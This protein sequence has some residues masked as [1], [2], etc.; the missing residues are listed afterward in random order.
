MLSNERL[1]AYE[2]Q[3]GAKR[4]SLTF[5]MTDRQAKRYCKK[6]WREATPREADQYRRAV[7]AWEAD[8]LANGRAKKLK[9]GR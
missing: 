2:K 7:Q 8:L 4:Y 3:M 9:S 1:L 5:R 6:W